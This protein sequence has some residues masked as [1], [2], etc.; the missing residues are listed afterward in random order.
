MAGVGP[1][2]VLFEFLKI[3]SDA[4]LKNTLIESF[5]EE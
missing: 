1:K 2:P 4:I 5:E 3:A